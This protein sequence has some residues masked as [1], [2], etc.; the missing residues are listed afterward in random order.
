MAQFDVY[1]LD[2]ALLLDL[3]T[4]LLGYFPSR[5]VAPLRRPGTELVPHPRLNPTVSV[6]EEPYVVV[7]QHASAVRTSILG[8]PIDNLDQ[9]YDQIKSAY[10][11]VFNGF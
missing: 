1:R 10:D 5:L 4:D 6:L 8:E 11:M 9:F 7:I 2:G 3:Q